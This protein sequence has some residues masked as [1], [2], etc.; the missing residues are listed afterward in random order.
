MD[1][2]ADEGCVKC[3]PGTYSSGGGRVH[4]HWGGSLPRGFSTYC[5]SLEEDFCAPWELK[6][7]H[8]ESGNQKGAD[9]LVSILYLTVEVSFHHAHSRTHVLLS[10]FRSW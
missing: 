2:L 6:G 8:I 10:S 3:E 9:G 4:E 5:E 1:L 7:D